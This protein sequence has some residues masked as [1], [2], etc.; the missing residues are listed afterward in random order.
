M[1]NGNTK[2]VIYF[3]ANFENQMPKRNNGFEDFE[4]LMF[5]F[6]LAVQELTFKNAKQML[7]KANEFLKKVLHLA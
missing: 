3:L 2:T 1:D 4:Y 6:D 5:P 7:R